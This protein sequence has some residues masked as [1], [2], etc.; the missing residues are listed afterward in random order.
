MSPTFAQ[1]D[2]SL[3]RLQ[4]AL[5]ESDDK[6]E[7]LRKEFCPDKI[8]NGK[9]YESKV[10]GHSS[11]NS[12]TTIENNVEISSGESITCQYVVPGEDGKLKVINETILIPQ[13]SKVKNEN[14]MNEQDMD[15][16]IV[17]K[18][19]VQIIEI[20]SKG[21]TLIDIK[22]SPPEMVKVENPLIL[23]KPETPE[24]E[25]V[26]NIDCDNELNNLISELVNDKNKNIIA[27]QFELTAM[28]VAEEV[29]KNNQE[30]FE[31]LIDKKKKEMMTIKSSE[32]VLDKLN[33]TY[34]KFGL[35]D[36][37]KDINKQLESQKSL[38]Y[39]DRN[40][41][42][43]N[44]SGSAMILAYQAKYPKSQLN[45]NDVSIVW[46][47]NKI[48]DQAVQGYN[49]FSK[50]ANRT[51]LSNRVAFYTGAVEKNRAKSVDD[52]NVLIGNEKTLLESEFE[53][54]AA[55]FKAKNLTCYNQLFADGCSHSS[56]I[57]NRILQIFASDV[58]DVQTKINVNPDLKIQLKNSY[59]DLGELGVGK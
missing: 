7:E 22:Y 44:T 4:T 15:K 27:H 42:L 29:V 13:K 58:S 51:N 54:L 57:E 50:E 40:R 16:E 6:E 49:K 32:E 46:L 3:K 24:K 33:T 9:N 23:S 8:I 19:Q 45:L 25:V 30:T 53:K 59:V 39:Y 11:S 17:A 43:T 14:L 1:D 5:E 41:R 36:D 10:T 18:K 56:L 12:K 31:G 55:T 47:M 2:E 48:S 52:L 34:Q 37:L 26:T 35:A 21:P 38:S 20:K 28:K